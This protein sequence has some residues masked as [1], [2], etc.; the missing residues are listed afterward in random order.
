MHTMFRFSLIICVPLILGITAKPYKPRKDNAE[1]AFQHTVMSIDPSGKLEVEPPEE[2]QET[3]YDISPGMRIWKSMAGRGQDK[4]SLKTEMFSSN[5]LKIQVQNHDTLPGDDI[6]TGASQEDSQ[7]HYHQEPEVDNDHIDHPDFSQ[8]SSKEPEQDWDDV[9]HDV[10]E[11]MQGYLAPLKADYNAPAEV[12]VHYSEPENDEV[13]LYH[14]DDQGLP[15]HMESLKPEVRRESEVRVHLEPEEDL[16][17]L[18]HKDI[19]MPIPYKGDAELAK[20]AAVP[21]P[22]KHSEPEEDQDDLHHQ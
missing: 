9:Y 17:D 11:E 21:H 12:P 4:Q 8:V 14:R 15:G 16:D 1:E 19:L 3:D 2:M 20:P 13:E 7:M 5:L 22:K 6:Q 18:Y 10:M